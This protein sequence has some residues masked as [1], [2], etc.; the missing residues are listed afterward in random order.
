MF[1]FSTVCLLKAADDQHAKR[2]KPA[3]TA[4]SADNRRRPRE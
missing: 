3:G 1:I 4:H 2:F